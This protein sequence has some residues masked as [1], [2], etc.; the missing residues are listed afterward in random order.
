MCRYN[1]DGDRGANGERE[2]DA[3]RLT[4]IG[5]KGFARMHV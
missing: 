2:K 5:M 4:K 3:K 1:T